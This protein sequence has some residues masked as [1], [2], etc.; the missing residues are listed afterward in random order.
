MSAG[1]SLGEHLSVKFS[2]PDQDNDK[3]NLNCAQQYRSGWWFDSC[4]DANLNG[5]Y[6]KSSRIIGWTSGV[7]WNAWR[8]EGYSL[9]FVEMKIRPFYH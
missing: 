5:P 9:K 3:W 4:S 8:G 7:E 2:T 1:D 6:Q